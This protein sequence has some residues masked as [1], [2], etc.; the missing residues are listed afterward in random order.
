[1]VAGRVAAS[2]LAQMRQ[3]WTCARAVWTY[4]FHPRIRKAVQNFIK[5]D[6]ESAGGR[7]SARAF[8]FRRQGFC[9]G[10]P[11]SPQTILETPAEASERR[12]RG[13]PFRRESLRQQ[14]SSSMAL[15]RLAG[16]CANWAGLTDQALTFIFYCDDKASAHDARAGEPTKSH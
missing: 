15:S 14:E 9:S 5:F 1:V 13:Q 11:S 4:G 6:V 3:S 8:F 7:P 2:Q 10:M 12:E 16:T